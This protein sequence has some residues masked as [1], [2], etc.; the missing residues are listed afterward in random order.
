MSLSAVALLLSCLA[1][2]VSVGMAIDT[3]RINRK[4]KEINKRLER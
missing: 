3:S 1:F 2:V 4:T